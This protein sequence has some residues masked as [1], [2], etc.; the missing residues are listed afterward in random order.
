MSR[1]VL[2]ALLACG[3]GGAAASGGGD[4][5]GGDAGDLA[6]PVDQASGDLPHTGCF[7][8]CP[9]SSLCVSGTI[10]HF[11]DDTPLDA[12]ETVHIQAYDALDTRANG[13]NATWVAKTD[14]AG[15]AYSLRCVTPPSSG[16]IA[17]AVSDPPGASQPQL[18]VTAA[19]LSAAGGHEY[20]VDLY[21]LTRV[22]V[23]TWSAQE[24]V[25]Y[26]SGSLIG[27]FF[28]DAARDASDDFTFYETT[29][30]AGAK[31]LISGT[32][33]PPLDLAFLGPT[34]ANLDASLTST[35]TLGIALA[36]GGGSLVASPAKWPSTF[37]GGAPGMVQIARLHAQGGD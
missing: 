29:P 2:A 36:T 12:T 24:R 17:L 34:R 27:F 25:D 30:A 5:G 15:S 31:W 4:G 9:A 32:T 11:A 21:A 26:A 1:A 18:V 7:A 35:G 28:D 14:V 37:A 6:A 20:H 10:H 3:C 16:L 13:T 33:Q 22:Q 8:S 23:A 19:W